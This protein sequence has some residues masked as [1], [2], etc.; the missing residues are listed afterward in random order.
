MEDPYLGEETTEVLT[1]S[2]VL[3]TQSASA[4]NFALRWAHYLLVPIIVTLGVAANTLALVVY[5][6]SR[7]R[8][9]SCSIYLASLA[10]TDSGFLICLF[11]RWLFG[12]YP[13]NLSSRFCPINYYFTGVFSLVSTVCVLSCTL[14]RYVA[15]CWPLHKKIWCTKKRAMTAI[16]T[17]FIFSLVTFIP[18]LFMFESKLSDNGDIQ[19]AAKEYYHSVLKWSSIC[20]LFTFWVI[21]TFITIGLNVRIIVTLKKDEQSLE[22]HVTARVSGS[23]QSINMTCSEE[24]MSMESNTPR[25]WSGRNGCTWKR[26]TNIRITRMLVVCSSAFIIMG[27]PYEILKEHHYFMF[28]TWSLDNIIDQNYSFAYKITVIILYHLYYLNFGVD[29]FIYNASGSNFREAMGE[30]M[31]SFVH[32]FFSACS[33]CKQK[34]TYQK[35]SMES[36]PELV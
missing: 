18:I 25:Q 1:I 9:V 15:T 5:V 23:R 35:D 13:T 30:V 34:L 36:R 26:K 32:C 29:F 24:T 28:N 22:L 11:S 10:I 17:S 20:T 3:T 12:M 4:D 14:E 8:S 21:P 16:G 2:L 7:L 6:A 19:C 31:Q 27:L 33:T